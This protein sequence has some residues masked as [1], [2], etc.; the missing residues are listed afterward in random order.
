MDKK[1]AEHISEIL[2]VIAH[3]VRLQILELLRTKEMC[4]SDI[5]ETLTGKQ[6]ITSQQ[7]NMMKNKGVL[8]RRRN[9]TRVY[10]HIENK[11]VNKLMRCI[12][13][14]CKWWLMVI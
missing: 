12:D 6:A 13:R 4:V 10:Y 3:S 9:G 11:N 7:L 1:V 2:K 14:R 5:V 8:C